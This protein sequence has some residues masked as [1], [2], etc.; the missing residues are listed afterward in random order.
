MDYGVWWL[1]VPQYLLGVSCHFDGTARLSKN[2]RHRLQPWNV[3]T[4]VLPF[5]RPA[6]RMA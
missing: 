2:Q 5:L 3:E 6:A 4:H 1:M